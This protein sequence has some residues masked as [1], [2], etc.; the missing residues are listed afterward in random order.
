MS[1]SEFGVKRWTAVDRPAENEQKGCGCSRSVCVFF[2][3]FV[4]FS[5]VFFTG[6]CCTYPQVEVSVI[7]SEQPSQ[8]FKLRERSSQRT[9]TSREGACSRGTSHSEGANL[10]RWVWTHQSRAAAAALI[11]LRTAA[12]CC[13]CGVMVEH[14]H[15]HLPKREANPTDLSL[16]H[17]HYWGRRG[18]WRS[19]VLLA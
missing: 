1:I 16:F 13:A 8:D 14:E 19:L 6:F 2:L 10:A 5:C 17:R 4:V 7:D 12:A 3:C 9:R 15:I 18:G 11:L